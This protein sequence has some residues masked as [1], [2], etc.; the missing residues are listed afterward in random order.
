MNKYG[1]IRKMKSKF[2]NHKNLDDLP[3]KFIITPL[4]EDITN[5]FYQFGIKLISKLPYFY[6]WAPGKYKNL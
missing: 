6:Q 1:S 5:V 2:K 3:I 4:K